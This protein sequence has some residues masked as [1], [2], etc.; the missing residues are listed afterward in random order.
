[1]G[2]IEQPFVLEIL[3]LD[4][5]FTVMGY[6]PNAS[7][8]LPNPNSVEADTD[9]VRRCKGNYLTSWGLRA[10][11]RRESGTDADATLSTPCPLCECHPV[12]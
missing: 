10:S 9:L 2:S 4:S 6:F 8:L 1:M 5:V 7:E 11:C 3:K 12:V